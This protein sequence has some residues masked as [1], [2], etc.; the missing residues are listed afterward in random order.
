MIMTHKLYLLLPLLACWHLHAQ[1]TGGTN[2]GEDFS[3]L[4]GSRLN[5]NIASFTVLYQGSS[6]DGHDV[7]ANQLIINSSD[8]KI[9]QGSSG[10]GFSQKKVAT[11]I[12]G[13]N[14]DNLFLGDSGDGFSSE[15]L[16]SLLSNQ[17]LAILFSGNRGDGTTQEVLSSGFLEGFLADIFNGGSGDG[18]TTA[19]KPNTYL[20]GLMLMLYGGGQGDGFATNIL[21]SA[22]TLKVEEQLA[23]LNVLLYPNP[24]SHIVNI[25]LSDGVTIT[26]IELYDISGKRINI[27]LSNE[28]TLN[29]KNLSNGVYLLNIVS[30]NG[31][32]N[33]K[34]IV[35]K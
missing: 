19:F 23:G 21:T 24:A 5:G 22:L 26:S 6:G 10:D 17:N 28:N 20:S 15:T 30:Q 8:F 25:K 29:V 35:K 12:N 11:T 7:N 18:F 16:Q 32:V 4:Y 27:D 2:D 1:F 9:Y 14:V 33:K 31:I 34:L 13:N 3:T